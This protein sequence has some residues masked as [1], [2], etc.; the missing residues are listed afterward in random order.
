MKSGAICFLLQFILRS[1]ENHAND[2]ETGREENP[3]AGFVPEDRNCMSESKSFM[4]YQTQ[5]DWATK[6]RNV[7]SSPF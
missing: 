7:G 6:H 2:K 3:L 4:F 5:L 1:L